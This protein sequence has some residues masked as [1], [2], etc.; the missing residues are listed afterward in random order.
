MLLGAD[1]QELERLATTIGRVGHELATTHRTI[2][3]VLTATSWT[4][5]DATRFRNSWANDQG[6][7]RRLSSSLEELTRELQRNA[8]EQ[9]RASSLS[10]MAGGTSAGG[11]HP[12]SRLFDAI[13]SGGVDLARMAAS[14]GM[15]PL[16]LV[17]ALNRAGMTGAGSPLSDYTRLDGRASGSFGAD[18]GHF[19]LWGQA[20]LGI[21]AAASTDLGPG[22]L[23]AR[24]EA[25]AGAEGY[26]VGDLVW[27]EDGILATLEAGGFLGVKAEGTAEYSIP[28]IGSASV[29]ASAAAGLGAWLDGE[30]S[31]SWDKVEL[32]L[33]AGLVFG[34]GGEIGLGLE[35]SPAEI[36]DD[37]VEFV[38]DV[39]DA[40]GDAID[41]VGDAFDDTADSLGDAAKAVG[42]FL[43]W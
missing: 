26:A 42:D 39:G 5:P 32:A 37:A 6:A 17:E 38:D 4:G 31:V 7:L 23:A 3:G 29:N 15:G 8:R 9:T 2:D 14:V 27:G 19:E 21:D 18:G 24:L 40:V 10:G 1:V 12:F 30:A 22:T 25:F 41:D 20:G 28:G 13:A 33:D 34:V 11:A 35:F 16:A 43:G 36:Y